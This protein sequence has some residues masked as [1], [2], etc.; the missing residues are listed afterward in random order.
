MPRCTPRTLELANVAFGAC[1]AQSFDLGM[2]AIVSPEIATF[3]KSRLE[4][5][6]AANLS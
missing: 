3:P 4:Y 5:D 6:M 2:A 1:A